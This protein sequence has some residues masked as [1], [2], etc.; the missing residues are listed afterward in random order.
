MNLQALLMEIRPITIVIQDEAETP[1]PP[2]Q[3]YL[4]LERRL[5][6]CARLS[7]YSRDRLVFY[8]GETK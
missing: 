2:R 8:F 6:C 1:L 7:L 4:A 3:N 5:P